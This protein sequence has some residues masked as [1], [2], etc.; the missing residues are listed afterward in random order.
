MQYVIQSM[1]NDVMDGYLKLQTE[2]RPL[3]MQEE[4]TLSNKFPLATLSKGSGQ[5]SEDKAATT[6]DD[7]VDS[8]HHVS[9][10]ASGQNKDKMEDTNEEVIANTSSNVTVD[11]NTVAAALVSLYTNVLVLLCVLLESFMS[12]FQ[13]LIAAVSEFLKNYLC[14]IR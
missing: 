13:I 4:G 11:S 8:S 2:S 9:P 6:K 10:M 14:I 1:G 3:F 7:T 12:N 5:E